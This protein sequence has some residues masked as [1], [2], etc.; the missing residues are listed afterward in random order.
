M[1]KS[2]IITIT[3]V[4][5]CLPLLYFTISLIPFDAQKLIS[6]YQASVQGVTV[7]IFGSIGL[8][9]ALAVVYSIMVIVMI[10]SVIGFIFSF[11]RRHDFDK[12][13]RI[14]SY[15]L[16]LVFVFCFVTTFVKLITNIQ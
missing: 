9:V 1:R 2:K 7:A 3:L 8:G 14:T 13:I 6:D 5:I 15:I 10:V 16:D 11:L 4:I 12:R